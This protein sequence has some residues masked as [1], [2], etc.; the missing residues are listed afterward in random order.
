MADMEANSSFA[1]H[2]SIFLSN[3]AGADY[4]GGVFLYAT[5]MKYKILENAFRRG[6]AID[7]TRGR[8][9]VS[10]GGRENRRCRLPTR[11]GIRSVLQIWWN[12][13]VPPDCCHLR[14]AGWI[15][16]HRLEVSLEMKTSRVREV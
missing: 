15:L 11:A 16:K 1:I 5:M 12:V 4:Q 3:G 2:T 8:I 13:P 7:G 6:L 14:R 10:S 9:V